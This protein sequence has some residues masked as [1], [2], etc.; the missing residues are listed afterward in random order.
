MPS[1]NHSYR[2]IVPSPRFY[3][4]ICPCLAAVAAVSRTINK[5]T[6]EGIISR[7]RFPPHEALV[8]LTDMFYGKNIAAKRRKKYCKVGYPVSE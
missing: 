2:I 4:L 6:A 5:W 1:V 3:S 8:K 7:K